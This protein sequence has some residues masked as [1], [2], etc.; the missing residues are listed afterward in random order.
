MFAADVT[1]WIQSRLNGR[2]LMLTK[3]GS[4]VLKGRDGRVE[5]P[6]GELRDLFGRKFREGTN[7]GLRTTLAAELGDASWERARRS[8]R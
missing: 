2:R 1:D 5:F 3:E 8:G 4:V 7:D 6:T